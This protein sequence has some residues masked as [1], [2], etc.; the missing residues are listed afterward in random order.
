MVKYKKRYMIRVTANVGRERRVLPPTYKTRASARKQVNKILSPAKT[1]KL[2]NGK[3][4]RLT[5]YRDAQSGVGLNNPRIIKRKT[6][7]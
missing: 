3:T 2:P 4:I 7:A 6:I 1:R 5:S